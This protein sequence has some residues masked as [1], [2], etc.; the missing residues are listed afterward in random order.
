MV[1]SVGAL[2]VDG[3]GGAGGGG[4]EVCEIGKWEGAGVADI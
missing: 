2:E 3:S 4:V 1:E